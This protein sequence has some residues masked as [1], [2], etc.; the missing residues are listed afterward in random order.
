MDS[1]GRAGEG[2]Q[3]QVGQLPALPSSSTSSEAFWKSSQAEPTIKIKKQ[4]AKPK[5]L[6]DT[7]L[8]GPAGRAE[9]PVCAFGIP[10]H[11]AETTDPPEDEAAGPLR[12]LAQ[13]LESAES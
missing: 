5:A 10:A 13:G 11:A 1:D 2:G 3:L 12:V 8:E 4:K 9:R 7:P 6:A